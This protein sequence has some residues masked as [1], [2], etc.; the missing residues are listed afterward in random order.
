MFVS[1]LP[2]S[3]VD[4]LYED[5]ITVDPNNFYILYTIFK[6][7]HDIVV[8]TTQHPVSEIQ[9]SR[10]LSWLGR[11]WH[12]LG[13]CVRCRAA[14]ESLSHKRLCSELSH[15]HRA[16]GFCLLTSLL[17]CIFPLF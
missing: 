7:E 1:S 12:Y 8:G 11:N 14:V 2:M 6:R 9:A 15:T 5:N 17:L 10:A 16:R 13:F 3:D 4:I